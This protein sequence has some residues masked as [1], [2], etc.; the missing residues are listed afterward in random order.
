MNVAI[1]G[2][3]AIGWAVA[4]AIDKGMPGI[5]LAAVAV[6]D[7]DAAAERLRMLAHPPA[8]VALAALADHG[9]VVVECAGAHVLREMAAPV[10]ASGRQLVAM[11]AGGFVSS[12]ALTLLWQRYRSQIHIPSGALGGLDAV[13][14]MAEGH[15]DTVRLVSTK[16]AAA[17]RG[18]PGLTQLGIDLQSLTGPTQVFG[19]TAAQALELFPD[20]LNVAAALALAGAGAHRTMV[21]LWLDPHA[22]TNRHEVEVLADSG[23]L[24]FSMDAMPSSNPRTSS[25]A[26]QS[27]LALLR[28]L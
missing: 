26:A 7:P 25:L 28:R 22:R 17:L 14:A 11:S 10:L 5:T 1:A 12:P 27:V 19:G 3:G 23:R 18:A 9:D 13:A 6:R 21:E 8:C 15:I 20:N 4:N 2:L 16:P 24:R